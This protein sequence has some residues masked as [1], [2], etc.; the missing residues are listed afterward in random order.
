MLIT[1][2]INQID[3][4]PFFSC[5]CCPKSLKAVT[6]AEEVSSETFEILEEILSE[7]KINF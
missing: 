5:Q 6:K 4:S 7:L 2:L 1:S 3:L